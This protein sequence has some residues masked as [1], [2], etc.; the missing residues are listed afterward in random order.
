MKRVH[1]ARDILTLTR[2]IDSAVLN[3]D[4]AINSSKIEIIS[5]HWYIQHYTP[6][7]FQ[8]AMFFEQIQRKTP[9]EP[10]NEERSL[11]IKNKNPQ[12]F[13]NF[14]LGTQEVINVP[15]R[16]FVGFQEVDRQ[17]SQNLNNDTFCRPP[18]TSAHV[19]IGK[20]R[21]P[22]NSVL[23]NYDNDVY[24]QAYGQIKEAFKALK[25][26][27]FLQPYISE[28]DIRSSNDGDNIA[29]GLHVCDLRYQKNIESAEPSKVE[30]KFQQT[31]PLG[32]MVVL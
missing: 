10:K 12:S 25:Q 23:I 24:P 11:F 1:T 4:N 27:E 31:S 19:V 6:S 29:Y 26:D 20:E 7:I 16:I 18:V 9:T 5:M 22:D 30:F 8:Q 2:N 14:E 15:I 13:W 3:K 17:N 28:H 32:Y 21:Y